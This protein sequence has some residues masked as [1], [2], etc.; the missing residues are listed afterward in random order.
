MEKSTCNNF[1]TNVK[2]AKSRWIKSPDTFDQATEIRDLIKLY[3]NY[4]STGTWIKSKEKDT[5]IIAMATE[6]YKERL[7]NLRPNDR[8]NR[9]RKKSRANP[10]EPLRK[11]P[12]L[13]PWRFAFDGKTKTE[14]GVKYKWCAHHGHKNDK[15]N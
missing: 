4:A 11:R 10:R 8:S 1:L 5:K 13:D 14:N 2:D 12:P 6:L 7:R 3:T 9:P 15:G